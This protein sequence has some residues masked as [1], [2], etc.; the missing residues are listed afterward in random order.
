MPTFPRYESYKDS[1][2]E[3]LGE[4]PNHW[5]FHKLKHIAK[6]RLSNVDKHSRAN[7]LPVK[8]CNYTDVYYRNFIT[9][10]ISFMEATATEEQVRSFALE[11]GD[12]LITKDSES[13]DD[14]AVPAYVP[15]TLANTICGYHLAHIKPTYMEGSYLFRAF[16]AEGISSQFRVSANGITRFGIGKSAINDAI[17]PL[18]PV[19][20][21]KR[22]VEFLDRTTTEI[23]RAISQK[24]RLI[25][26]LQEQKAIV[27]NQA[28]TQG[29]NPK[30]SMRDSGLNWL[31]SIPPH[32]DVRRA[33]FLFR[34]VDERSQTGTEE[35]LSVSHMTGV[36]PRSEKNVYMFMAEDYTGSKLCRKDDLVIN[37]M[38]AWMGALGVSD[39]IG[40]VSPSYGVFR[41]MEP[42]TFN[43]WYLEHLLRSTEYV[44]QYNRISTGLHSSRLRLYA[45]MF[46][47]MEIL[48]PPK[49]EQDRITS[50]TLERTRQIDEAINSIESEITT[51]GDLRSI[52]ISKAVT[53]KIKV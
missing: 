32:W 4:I 47:G 27:I 49:K 30:A 34:E 53:G 43:S 14:I 20:E 19:E 17:F 28:V 11:K 52:L 12:V 46:L 37:I 25:E 22:I 8:L 40:I 13:F 24:Q 2:V 31:G 44:A 50:V 3:W 15:E 38:W 45:H 39:R 23:D 36:T 33:K 41:Q 29:L 26:L 35:L 10:E 18:P 48:L 6:V 1:G 42:D 5:N 9:S 7:E 21:Q 51:L 16:Q